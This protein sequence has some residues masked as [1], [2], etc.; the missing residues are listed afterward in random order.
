[1]SSPVSAKVES[2]KDA[3]ETDFVLHLHHL[4]ELESGMRRLVLEVNRGRNFGHEG[5]AFGWDVL[6]NIGREK[7]ESIT[8]YAILAH[9]LARQHLKA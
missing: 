9:P 4:E 5:F 6:G 2:G 8:S 1:M 3:H 7:P